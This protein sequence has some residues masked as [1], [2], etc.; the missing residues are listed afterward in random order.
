MTHGHQKQIDESLLKISR[1]L[2]PDH[3]HGFSVQDAPHFLQNL[4]F[5]C[6]GLPQLAH[7]SDSGMPQFSPNSASA[8]SRNPQ[9]EHVKAG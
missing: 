9:F 1:A 2:I 7:T 5:G 3:T 6:C 8:S 4:A